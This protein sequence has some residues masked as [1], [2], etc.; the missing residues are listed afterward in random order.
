VLHLV[1]SF[2]WSWSWRQLRVTYGVQLCEV[3]ELETLQKEDQK[4]LRSSEMCC[5]RRTDK[6]SWIDRVRNLEVL[7]RVKKDRNML[8]T[9]QR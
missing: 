2:V 7:Q 1:Y 9:M 4:Y 3:L 5:W 6:I 8:H